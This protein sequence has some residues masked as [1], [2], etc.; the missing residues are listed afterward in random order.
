MANEPAYPRQVEQAKPSTEF[1]DA[2]FAQS[3]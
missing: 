2:L 1:F 3:R